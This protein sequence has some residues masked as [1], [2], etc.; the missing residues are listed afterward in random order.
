MSRLAPVI[1]GFFTVRLTQRRAAPATVAAYRDTFRLLLDFA[2][3]QK[4]RPPCDLDLADIDA[5]M[6]G[7]FLD[8]LETARANSLRTRNLRLT[9]IHSLFSY[10]A[11]RCPEHSESIRR[12]L[13]IP[14]KRTGT[15]LVNFLTPTE[16]DALLAVID[17]DSLLGERDHLLIVVAVQT[18]LRV[19]ELTALAFA[20]ITFGSGA[21][22]RTRGK[23]RKDRITPLTR[24]TTRL[25]QDYQQHRRAQL[26]DPVFANRLGGRLSND[27][28]KDLLDKHVRAAT[29]ICPSLTTKTI[30]PH[31]LRHTCA[32]N[33]LQA[34]IDIATIALWLGHASTKA[35][36]VYLHADLALKEQA[37]ALTAPTPI[38]RKRFRPPDSLLAFLEA[39]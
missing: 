1:E 8:H 20:D 29:S 22:L 14:P 5:D 18:G 17:R 28:V 9:A 25:L 2:Y 27:A 10:A 39:L 30:T 21:H 35:T 34:G 16:T 15:T 13:A 24:S 37:L 3:K 6:V 11:L 7:A 23:G 33:M 12:V 19:S 38:A 31:T 26:Q 32:M 36:Q 4:G